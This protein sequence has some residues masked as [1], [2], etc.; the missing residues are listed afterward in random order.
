[1]STTLWAR[2]GN[3]KCFLLFFLCRG[4]SLFLWDEEGGKELV[5]RSP[6]ENEKGKMRKEKEP[7]GTENSEELAVHAGLSLTL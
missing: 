1:M 2:G 4:I 5:V 3:L 7:C 6:K